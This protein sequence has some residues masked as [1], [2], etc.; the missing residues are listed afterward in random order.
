MKLINYII[1]WLSLEIFLSSKSLKI[2]LLGCISG[3]PWVL[4]GSSL[5]LWLKDY[6]L[7]RSSIGWAGL[8]FSV[9]ALNFLWAPFVDK[10]KI[11]LLTNKF[12]HRKSWILV[13][14]SLI[15]IF[16]IC[17]FFLSPNEHL[18]FV[19]LIGL[20]IAICSA[21]QDITLDALRIE[22]V[23]T[24]EKQLIA[25][26]ASMMVIGWWTGF[27]LGGLISLVL[28]DYFEMLKFE[29]YWQITFLI[30]AM[31]M[32][33]FNLGVLFID[34]SNKKNDNNL[35]KENEFSKTKYFY[36]KSLQSL[37]KYFNWLISTLINPIL[38]FFKK[39]G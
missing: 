9:Y 32:V 37:S 16:L 39:T 13:L 36:S 17:W 10:L 38:H 33:I 1:S 3:Y 15:I 5:T 20:L 7:S 23:D 2:F 24:T 6:E 22:Q 26:G 4:I 30:L 14:Q 11:P 28:A 29:N 8:I 35:R 27:K 18:L 25:A 12:G 19:I 21:T 31:I 34:E